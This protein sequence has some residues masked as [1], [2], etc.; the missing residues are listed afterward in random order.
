[1]GVYSSPRPRFPD[2]VDLWFSCRIVTSNHLS[3]RELKSGAFSVERPQ[4]ASP[5]PDAT[6]IY[7]AQASAATQPEFLNQHQ[8]CA[9][10]PPLLASFPLSLSEVQV[11]VACLG[12]YE[13][14]HRAGC[15]A[16][17]S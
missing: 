5:Q 10:G 4:E 9:N 2:P 11:S 3:Q 15:L 7:A 12:V 13:A 17:S 14:Q 16:I 6:W 1:M 8:R